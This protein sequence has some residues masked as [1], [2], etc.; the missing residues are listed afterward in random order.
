MVFEN[1]NTVIET[2]RSAI[3]AGCL[4]FTEQALYVAEATETEFNKLFE[5]VGID[6]LA[7][8]ESTGT[9][10]VYEGAKLDEFKNKAINL[11]KGIWAKIKHAYELI[12]DKF[13]EM[14]YGNKKNFSKVSAADLNKLDS[15]MTFG[16]THHFN[17]GGSNARERADKLVK[18]IKDIFDLNR[19]SDEKLEISEFQDKIVS[20]IS[21]TDKTS[22]KEAKTE[23]SKKLIG[24]EF[25]VDL[26][27]VKKNLD[28]LQI[29]VFNPPTNNIKSSFNDEKKLIDNI[30]KEIKGF[31]SEDVNSAKTSIG[32]L[33]DVESTLHTCMSAEMDVLKRKYGEY[34]NVFT[35]VYLAT[36]KASKAKKVTESVED[37]VTSQQDLVESCFDWD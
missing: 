11:F 18:D 27:W 21:G 14:T 3:P 15:E 35:K 26:S 22:I 23:L 29:T 32:L 20:E 34:R 13:K 28:S 37:V 24:D 36:K 2:D 5:S 8:F 16:K 19:T 1:L 9:E 7:V 30:I 33:K 17:F 4:S 10:V 6:E 12:T 25:E 31:K